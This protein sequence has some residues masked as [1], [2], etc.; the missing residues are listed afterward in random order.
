MHT[1]KCR[2]P[3]VALI[4]ILGFCQISYAQ[5]D[6]PTQKLADSLRRVG[7]GYKNK[8]QYAEALKFY[9]QSLQLFSTLDLHI[10]VADCHNKIGIVHY[11]LADYDSALHHYYISLNLND[12]LEHKPGTLKN[13]INLSNYFARTHDYQSAS[14]FNMRGQHLARELGNKPRLAHLYETCGNIFLEKRNPNLNFDSARHYFSNALEIFLSDNYQYGIGG[15]YQN[16]GLVFERKD[17]LDS[18]KFYYL[19][20]LEI[21]KNINSRPD[22]VSLYQNLGNIEKKSSRFNSALDYYM[23]GFELAQSLGIKGR[24]HSLSGNIAEVYESIGNFRKALSWEKINHAYNDT[25]FNE[26]KARQIAELN[27]QY[28][29]ERTQQQLALS[30]AQVDRRTAERDGY[31]IALAVFLA[32]AIV[33]VWIY[34]QRQ[35]AVHSLRK[36]EKD[37]HSRRINELLLEQEV[38]SLNAMLDGQ[39]TERKRISQELHDRVGSLLTAAKYAFEGNGSDPESLG[40]LDNALEETRTLSHSLASGVL[41][42]FGLVAAISDLKDSIESERAIR[43]VYET[44]GFEGRIDQA[45]EIDLYRILQE[46]VSNTLKYANAQEITIRLE[47]TSHAVHIYYTDDGKGFNTDTVAGGIGLK[48]IEARCKKYNGQLAIE[49]QPTKGMQLTLTIELLPD[50][51]IIASG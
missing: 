45:I 37:L 22:Q 30:Q 7:L 43:L 4:L 11:R 18:A 48:N 10:E 50:E 12:S 23:N 40:L 6:D 28:E 15:A 8:A 3:L 2:I 39:E 31:L 5:D 29:T 35:K 13:Y 16:I 46:L 24:L 51:K 49:S 44:K 34:S 41:A 27:T 38:S 1:A 47:Q 19:K 26:N 32:L 14:E 42:K 20:S 21:K 33:L 25:I 17:D 36:K 9:H